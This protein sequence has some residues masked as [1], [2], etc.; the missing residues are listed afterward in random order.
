MATTL[1]L[2]IPDRIYQPLQ[3]RAKKRGKTLDQI[4]IEWLGN[5]V[6]DGPDD[7]LLQLAGAFSCGVKNIGTNHDIHIGQEL[8]N[9]HE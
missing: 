6:E 5:A 3:E 4:I 8:S 2:Q 9:T 7:P 1:T